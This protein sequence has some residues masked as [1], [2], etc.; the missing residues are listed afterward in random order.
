MLIVISIVW[1]SCSSLDATLKVWESIHFSVVYGNVEEP[2]T[3]KTGYKNI[4]GKVGWERKDPLPPPKFHTSSLSILLS[5][6]TEH[7]IYP[8]NF[9]TI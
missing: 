1:P 8:C 9:K 4:C 5:V 6:N 7:Y 3:M 2:H